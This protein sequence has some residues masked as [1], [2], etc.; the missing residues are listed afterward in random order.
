MFLLVHRI[1]AL[2]EINAASL[3]MDEKIA[4]TISGRHCLIS[5]VGYLND[6]YD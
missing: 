1:F 5:T 4:F 6:Q 2:Q 3:F